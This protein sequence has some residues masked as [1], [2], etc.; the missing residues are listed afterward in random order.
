VPLRHPFGTF[1][2]SSPRVGAKSDDV[3]DLFGTSSDGLDLRYARIR[4]ARS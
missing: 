2:V 4:L 1:F 3:V